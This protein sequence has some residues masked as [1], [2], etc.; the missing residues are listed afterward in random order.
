MSGYFCVTAMA[1]SLKSF[2]ILNRLLLKENP[3]PPKT[4]ALCQ[5]PPPPWV[6]GQKKLIPQIGL[7]ILAPLIN[8]FF[9]LRKKFQMWG[10]GGLVGAGQGLRHPPPLPGVLKQ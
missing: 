10:L 9:C 6:R 8:F 7:K 4:K 2:C 3:P 1:T 5:P